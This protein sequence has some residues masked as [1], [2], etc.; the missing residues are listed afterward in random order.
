MGPFIFIV[1]LT[2]HDAVLLYLLRLL[3]AALNHNIISE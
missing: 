2:W 1:S 3:L